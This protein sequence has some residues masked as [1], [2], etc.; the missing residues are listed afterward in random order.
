MISFHKN[1][2]IENLLRPTV[3]YYSAAGFLL[4][5]ISL[6]TL[7][8]YVL[9]SASARYD[10]TLLLL[11]LGAWRLWQGGCTTYYKRRLLHSSIFALSTKQ[12]PLD[13]ANLYLGHGFSWTAR[14]TQRLHMLSEQR[15]ERFTQH[16]RLYQWARAWEKKHPSHWL[17]QL[18]QQQTQWN[19][20]KPLPPVG[21]KTLDPQLRR[22]RESRL[23]PPKI[24]YRPYVGFWHHWCGKNPFCLYLN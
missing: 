4:G 23:Y 19:L 20:L 8:N 7:A 6:L 1:H 24:A 15:F 17:S 22:V 5:A 14:H 16:S 21:G 13:K 9:F 18:T 11:L 3:E 10:I 12:V 2:A